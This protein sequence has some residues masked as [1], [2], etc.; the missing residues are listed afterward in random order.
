MKNILLIAF[1]IVGFYSCKSTF[2]KL[3]KS[4]D[5]EYKFQKAVEYYNKEDYVRASTLFESLV[6]VWRG[7]SK[8]EDV[9]FFNAQCYYK[10]QDYISAGYYFRNFAKTFPNSKYTSEAFYLSAYCF[11][12]DS[13]PVNLDQ[14]STLQAINELELY[15]TRFPED[16]AKVNECNRL[17]DNLRLKLQ[18]KSFI[19]AKLYFDL[20]QYKAAIIALKNAIKDY[21]ESD[22]NDQL[23]YLVVKSCYLLA[24]NSI[25]TKQK[26]RFEK[27]IT[28]YRD[29]K[30]MFPKGKYLKEVEKMSENSQKQLKKIEKTT[31]NTK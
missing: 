23:K 12:L 9:N 19:N 3:E 5:Y 11:Y 1:V 14:S 30:D 7:T 4:T 17:I 21:P 31:N 22:Y 18:E 27:T 15:L 13:P 16:T 29:Y 6:N 25:E 20:G 28:E 8:A 2:S 26:E 10:M 24:S